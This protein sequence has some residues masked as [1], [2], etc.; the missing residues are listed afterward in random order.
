MV[1]R[2]K[3]GNDSVSRPFSLPEA[4]RR[5]QEEST[6]ILTVHLNG[7]C[8]F[9][10]ASLLEKGAGGIPDKDFVAKD[11]QT[12]VPYVLF[13]RDTGQAFL[14]KKRDWSMLLHWGEKYLK[15]VL[16]ESLAPRLREVAVDLTTTWNRARHFHTWMPIRERLYA[17]YKCRSSHESR[18]NGYGSP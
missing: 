18:G 15:K 7:N 6:R 11:R 12:G 2:I 3:D 16:P 5:A 17:T 13:E 14:N 4:F 9:T 10:I 1:Y 8:G